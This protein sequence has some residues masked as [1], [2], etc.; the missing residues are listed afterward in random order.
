MDFQPH[1]TLVLLPFSSGDPQKID[2]EIKEAT[3][4]EDLWVPPQVGIERIHVLNIAWFSWL[5]CEWNL[6]GIHESYGVFISTPWKIN[7]LN[8]QIIPLWTWKSS[9]PKPSQP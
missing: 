1:R 2:K 6:P 7:I 3:K 9:E 5:K 8:L 4:P